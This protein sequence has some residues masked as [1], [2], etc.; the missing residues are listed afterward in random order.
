MTIFN[1]LYIELIFL[2]FNFGLI[3]YLLKKNFF[4]LDDAESSIHKKGVQNK[5]NTPLSGGLFFIIFILIY[6]FQYNFLLIFFL[7]LIYLIGLFSD[8]NFIKSPSRRLIIQ[9]SIVM[10]YIFFSNIKIISINISFLDILLKNYYIN[11]IFVTFCILII[12]NGYNFIDGVNTLATGNFIICIS[13]IVLISNINNL[14][15]DENFILPVLLI[16]VVIFIF[17]F[18]GK[19]FLGDSGAYCIGFFISIVLIN[20]YFENYGMISP[21]YV[22]NLIWYPALENL[23]SIIRRKFNKKIASQPDNDHFH[24]ILYSHLL[25][26]IDLKNKFF[27]NTLTG[28]LINLYMLGSSMLA[29]NYYTHT[30]SLVILILINV[31]VYFSVYFYL[32]N[33]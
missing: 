21:Y 23:F 9:T 25:K 22:A 17:N 15:L 19:S 5:L 1:N 24:Q 29:F 6:F 4:L 8:L 30:V 31:I 20:F 16:L 18:F 7:I 12:I 32:Y 33:K 26:K 14:N 2:I 13:S 28:M 27:I 10:L 3:N 11:F